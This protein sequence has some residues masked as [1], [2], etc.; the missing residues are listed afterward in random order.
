M[1]TTFPWHYAGL[2]GMPRRMAYFDYANPAIAPEA[3]TVTM[4]FIGALILV[5]S[6][7]LFF[8]VLARGHCG[9]RTEVP[10]F[11]FAAAVHPPATLPVALNSFGLW[12]ALMIALTVVNY[13]YPIAQ[14]ATLKQTSVPAVWMGGS[15]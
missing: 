4:S 6:G 11:T 7:V 10:K 2:L 15:R 3:I 14:L 5:A 12:I 1:V 13:G 9:T 8:I